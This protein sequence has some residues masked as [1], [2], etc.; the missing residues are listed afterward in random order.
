[1]SIVQ[2]RLRL[3]LTKNGDLELM[4]DAEL[5]GDRGGADSLA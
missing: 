4:P 3:M 5:P 2:C 1:M